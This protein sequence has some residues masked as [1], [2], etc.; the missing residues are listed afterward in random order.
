M[1]PAYKD[2]KVTFTDPS[3]KCKHSKLTT[4]AGPVMET[5]GEDEEAADDIEVDE[6]M[7]AEDQ[8][9]AQRQRRRQ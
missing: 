6:G 8:P 4:T 1:F 3:R 2:G 7:Q 9:D 5:D